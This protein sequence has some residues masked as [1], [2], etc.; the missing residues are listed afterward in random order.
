MNRIKPFIKHI[1]FIILSVNGILILL[2]FKY[3]FDWMY[4]LIPQISGHGILTV[5][6]MLFYA[7]TH[8]FCLYSFACILGLGFLNILNL[9]HFFISFPYY[10]AYASIIIFAAL[11]FALIKWIQ[12][13]SF[14]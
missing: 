9:V 6:F 5:I 10:N 12:I 11:T 1:P 2:S 3:Q 14:K 13:Y 4:W 7:Y 8:R